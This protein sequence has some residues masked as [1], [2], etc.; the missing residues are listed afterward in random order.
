[1]VM[2]VCSTR[3]LH[4]RT[5]Q[6]WLVNS[7]LSWAT[8]KLMTVETAYNPLTIMPVY[9]F[10]SVNDIGRF[11]LLMMNNSVKVL[12]CPL[13][14]DIRKVITLKV[15]RPIAQITVILRWRDYGIG[16][17]MTRNEV[18]QEKKSQCQFVH[19]KSHLDWSG[20]EP[21]PLRR[22]AGEKQHEPV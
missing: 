5:T 13:P 3:I 21:G 2:Y 15:P 1:M 11:S 10:R 22:V 16:G 8:I 14:P 20:I 19:H 17:M 7:F 4:F 18:L 12:F 9:I 6:T